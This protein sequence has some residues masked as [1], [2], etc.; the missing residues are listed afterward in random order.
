MFFHKYNL[1]WKIQF[2]KDTGVTSQNLTWKTESP[3]V[4]TETAK[5]K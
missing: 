4:C 1:A 2:L 5:L 3:G